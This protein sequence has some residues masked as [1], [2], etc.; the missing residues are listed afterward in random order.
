MNLN[1]PLDVIFL[2]SHLYTLIGSRLPWGWVSGKGKNNFPIITIIIIVVVL[3][4]IIIIVSYPRAVVRDQDPYGL[5]I[6]QT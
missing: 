5:G 3:V 1:K 2:S 4:I 6:I